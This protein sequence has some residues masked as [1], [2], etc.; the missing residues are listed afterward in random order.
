[1]AFLFRQ[2]R[3]QGTDRRTDRRDATVNAAPRDGC[4]IITVK[5][6]LFVLQ[7]SLTITIYPRD[8]TTT[9]GPLSGLYALEG[10][11][12]CLSVHQL[13]IIVNR[14]WSTHAQ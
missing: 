4:I 7:S 9:E 1:M 13:H 14:T 11:F 2:K 8:S 12:S 10:F 3:R 6:W 5:R